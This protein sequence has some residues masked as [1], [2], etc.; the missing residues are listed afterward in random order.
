MAIQFSE[1]QLAL[2]RRPFIDGSLEVNEGTPR[3]GKTTA[4]AFRDRKSVV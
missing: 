1:K 3:S 4:G 2:I